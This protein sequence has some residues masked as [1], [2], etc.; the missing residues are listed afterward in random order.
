MPSAVPDVKTVHTSRQ[1]KAPFQVLP[2]PT[3]V[4]TTFIISCWRINFLDLFLRNSPCRS[5]GFAFPSAQAYRARSRPMH[6]RDGRF[7]VKSKPSCAFAARREKVEGA[8]RKTNFASELW[9]K[10]QGSTQPDTQGRP[11]KR[12]KSFSNLGVPN[13]VTGSHPLTASKPLVKHPGFLPPTTSSRTSGCRYKTSF[14]NPT[15]LLPTCLRL[16]LMRVM[17]EAHRGVLTEVPL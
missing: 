7:I 4:Y 9:S 13:P 5:P 10:E 12:C 11:R 17:I 1:T 15:G 3:L 14:T 8:P 6:E 2:L 16:E